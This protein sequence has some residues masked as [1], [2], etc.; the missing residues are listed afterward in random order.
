MEGLK[1]IVFFGE[2]LIDFITTNFTDDLLS[3]EGFKWHFGGSP[4]NIAKSLA[5]LEIEVTI[6]GK[7]G[8]DDFG[9]ASVKDLAYRGVD[10]QYVQ[11]DDS[12]HTSIVFTTRSRGDQTFLPM[13][14]ADFKIELSDR[15]IEEILENASF[16]HFSSWPVTK[17]PSRKTLTR[18]LDRAKK[19]KVRIC[20][21]VNYRKKL[22]NHPEAPK[23]IIEYL[24]GVYLVKPSVDDSR[25]L[26]G[27][28]PPEKYVEAYHRAGVENVVLT[29]GK[30][31]AMVSDG[32]R[33]K[34]IPSMARKIVNTLGAGDGFWTGI[35]YGL[36]NGKNIFEAAEIGSAIA[37]FRLE[38]EGASDPL[39][40]IQEILNTYLRRS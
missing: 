10:V 5:D 4:A 36:V 2:V 22:W 6:V 30:E 29:L 14:D 17:E 1:K 7:V 11:I 21:D 32:K 38:Q 31:G 16:F 24:E 23:T 35:Y 20:F 28:L 8:N 25:E 34:V 37:A 39:P 19:N 15:E 12:V 33:K 13:R 3:A 40:E 26:F 9:R 27:E 18:L